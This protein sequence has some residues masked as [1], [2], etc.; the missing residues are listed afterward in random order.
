M[1]VIG[2]AQIHSKLILKTAAWVALSTMYS[3]L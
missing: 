2:A 3:P 1:I